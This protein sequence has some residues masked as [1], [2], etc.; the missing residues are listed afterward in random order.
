MNKY[1]LFILLFLLV[2][3]GVKSEELNEEKKIK[4]Q[5]NKK[6]SEISLSKLSQSSLE[7]LAN[8]PLSLISELE[9]TLTEAEKIQF[10]L[11]KQLI[12][13][14]KKEDINTLR[15]LLYKGADANAKDIL[16]VKTALMYLTSSKRNPQDRKS[17]QLKIFNILTINGANIEAQN[18]KG[19]TALILAS[20][21]NNFEMIH[22]LAQKGANVKAQDK[23]GHTAFDD[24]ENKHNYDLMQVLRVALRVSK[25]IQTKN[26]RTNERNAQNSQQ[27]IEFRDTEANNMKSQKLAFFSK[28]G[29]FFQR[30]N[31]A[32]DIKKCRQI[33]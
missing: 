15:T 28:F 16:E 33:F 11:N 20:Q 1:K 29:I 9:S 21:S 22:A 2:S 24:P 12:E 32:T 27:D 3:H 7:K 30:N 23:N 19:E 5:L 25:H 17:I 13:A 26:E 31:E 18:N 8:D 10:Q 4:L 6:I 14:I